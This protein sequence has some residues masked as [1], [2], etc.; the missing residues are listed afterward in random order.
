MNIWV[1][2]SNKICGYLSD[3]HVF[4]MGSHLDILN[5]LYET[6]FISCSSSYFFYFVISLKVRV[7][8]HIAY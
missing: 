6:N 5:Y 7:E 2:G 1:F 3:Y 8:F 4:K